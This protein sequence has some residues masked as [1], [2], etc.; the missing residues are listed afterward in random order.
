[1]HR[2]IPIV[3]AMLAAAGATAGSAGAAAPQIY[4]PFLNEYSFIGMNCDGFD[5]QIEGAGTDTFTVWTDADGQI[6]K[7]VDRA[8]YPHDTLTN[9]VTGKAIV[10]RGEFQETLT[11]IPGTD[12][13]TKTITGFRYL[14]NE[15]GA[16]VTIRDVGRI[17]YGDLEQTLVLWEAGEHDLALDEQ[18]EPTFCAALS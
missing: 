10:N 13:A 5:I 2:F 9:T 1:M 16:G 4:G 17:T 3:L 7:V 14:V 18:I 8:R 12:E 15:R 11:P 6:T